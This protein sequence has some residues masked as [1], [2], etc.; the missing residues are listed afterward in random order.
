M[1]VLSTSCML[2]VWCAEKRLLDLLGRVTVH[3]IDLLIDLLS[4]GVFVKLRHLSPSWND[5]SSH[6]LIGHRFHLSVRF[7][8]L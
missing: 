8:K 5:G 7:L 4:L 1:L 3:A 2:A 6:A